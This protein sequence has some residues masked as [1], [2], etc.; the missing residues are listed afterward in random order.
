LATIWGFIEE[1]FFLFCA[2]LS[3][4]LAGLA[5]LYFKPHPASKHF[6]AY[7]KDLITREQA[8]EK[9]ANTMYNYRRDR[10][11][12]VRKSKSMERR[13]RWL[14][15]RIKAEEEF[16]NDLISYMKTKARME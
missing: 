8:I 1:Y 11:P 15:K 4:I 2:V 6:D 3:L 14:R 5:Y 9:I 10:L 13:I 7:K 16:I 12:S